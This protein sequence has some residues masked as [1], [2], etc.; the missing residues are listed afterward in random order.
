[1]VSL[2]CQPAYSAGLGLAREGRVYLERATPGPFRKRRSDHHP[3][4]S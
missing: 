3:T 2:P 4:S 1:M